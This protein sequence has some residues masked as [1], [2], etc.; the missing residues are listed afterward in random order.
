MESKHTYI[1]IE[2]KVRDELEKLKVIPRESWNEVV[3]RLLK[4][5]SVV[6]NS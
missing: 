4:N 6:T 3:K 5:K 1:Q 2:T